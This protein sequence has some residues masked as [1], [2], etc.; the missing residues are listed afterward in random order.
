[1]AK[2]AVDQAGKVKEERCLLNQSQKGNVM[3]EQQVF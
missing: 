1:M 3:I 2:A